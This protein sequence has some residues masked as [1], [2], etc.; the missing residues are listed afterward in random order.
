M[1]QPLHSGYASPVLT[2]LSASGNGTVFYQKKVR[3]HNRQIHK[4]KILK[5]GI[6]K[7][8]QAPYLVKWFRLFDKVIA[9]NKEWYINGRRIKGAFVLKN[10]DGNTLK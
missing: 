2:N 4:Q 5:G 7:R 6:R 1:F 8:N 3:C 10:L 9:K